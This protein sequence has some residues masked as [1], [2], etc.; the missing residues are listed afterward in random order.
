MRAA[1]EECQIAIIRWGNNTEITELRWLWKPLIPFG[2][3]TILEGDGGEG[4]TTLILTVAAGLSRGGLPPTLRDGKLLPADP[5]EPAATFYLTNEDEISDSSLRRFLRAGGDASRFA[6]SGETEHHVTLTEAELR[7]IIAETGARLV[8]IDPFQAFLPEGTNLGSITRMRTVFTMLSN[9]AR[10]TGAAIVLVG[11]LNKTRGGKEI[12]RG[13]GSADISAAVR[14]ILLVERD[15]NGN[16][17]VRAIKSNFDESDFTPVRLIFDEDR[18]LSFAEAEPVPVGPEQPE[19]AAESAADTKISRAEEHLRSMLAAGPVPVSEIRSWMEKEKI[20]AKTVQ[21]ARK[22]LG[23]KLVF[24]GG[25]R[26]WQLEEQPSQ[27]KMQ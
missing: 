4:K 3:V 25:V 12:H 14:S 9:V 17:Y 11:H 10:S 20:S 15:R 26:C 24:P 6:Y 22:W 2:K 7:Q 13:F 19:D 18:R 23:A 16:R 21:R 1:K 8:I 27:P 5:V